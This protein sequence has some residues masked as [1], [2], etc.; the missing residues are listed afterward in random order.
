[1]TSSRWWQKTE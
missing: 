1:M